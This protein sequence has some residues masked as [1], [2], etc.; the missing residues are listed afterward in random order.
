MPTWL[1][2][3]FGGVGAPR[4]QIKNDSGVVVYTGAQITQVTPFSTAPTPLNAANMND[5]ED[6]TRAPEGTLYNGK[7]AP[8]VGSG[9]LQVAIKTLAGNDPSPSD[10]VYVRLGGTYRAITAA[11]NTILAAGTNWCNAGGAE[12]ATKEAD[13]FVYLG[14]NATDGVTIGSSRIP[15]AAQYSD[16]STTT[17]NE[18]YARIS[19]ITN[20]AAADPYVNIGRFAATLSAG[21]GYTWSIPTYTPLNLVQRPTYETRWLAFV[22]VSTGFSPDYAR[23]AKYQVVGKNQAINIYVNGNGTSSTTGFTL[24]LPFSTSQ[25]VSGQPTLSVDNGTFLFSAW[26][27]VAASNIV[28]LF[29]GASLTAASWTATG[30]KFAFLNAILPI[31]D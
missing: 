1:D 14:Y 8:S 28:T 24:T 7:I 18:K 12:L 21:V 16:F 27:T 3:I 2:G 30:T 11:L 9:S 26:A 4:Y 31:G 17:T 25:A 10:P 6:R 29:K 13:Y 20:A 23:T 5:L 15:W 22:S 19:T